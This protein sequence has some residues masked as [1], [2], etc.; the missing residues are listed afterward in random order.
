M[1]T[2]DDA[3]AAGM[4]IVPG[5]TLANTIDTEINKTRDYI[6]QRTSAVQPVAK[7]GTGATSV[8]GARAALSVPSIASVDLSLSGK[9]A[10]SDTAAPG[11]ATPNKLAAYDGGGRIATAA[12]VSNEDAVDLGTL[13]AHIGAGA[14]IP[15]YS[16]GGPATQNYS[17]A[18]INGDGRISRG[19]SSERYKK[20][21]K[22]I[23][24]AELGDIWPELHRFQMKQ[25]EAG[26]WKYG[27]IA[28]RLH[29]SEDLRSFVVYDL[30]GR[31]DSIDFIGL[32]LAQNAQ[33]HQAVDLLTQRLESLE[34][35]WAV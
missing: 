9:V 22:A 23:D 15:I 11:I 17:V 26:A 28:E 31:P 2:G 8:E 10:Y 25:G 1:A 33:L 27:Y 5:T 29:E 13:A 30:E 12:P 19:A 7:G 18:Y 4:D 20:H 21:I 35:R 6:A 32:L 24:P 34:D 16:A 3:L 14:Y